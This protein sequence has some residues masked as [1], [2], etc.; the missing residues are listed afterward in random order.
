[1]H[2]KGHISFCGAFFCLK[3]SETYDAWGNH[4]IFPAQG[5]DISTD[6]S[7]NGDLGHLNPYI[8]FVPLGTYG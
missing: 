6:S 2:C 8:L 4:K 7:Y 3:N 5:I 1:M